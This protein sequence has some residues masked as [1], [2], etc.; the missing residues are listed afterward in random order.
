M[1]MVRKS[2][3][4]NGVTF[5]SEEVPRVRSLSI[6]VYVLAGSR[7]E[8]PAEA[9]L[10]HF[11]EHM[12][13]KGTS[14]R[15][16]FEIALSLEEVGGSLDAYT[17]RELT[18]FD[19]RAL[20]E[21]LPLAADVLADI[22]RNPVF[23]PA[24]V[25]KE[26]EVILEELKSLEDTPDDLVHD[27]FAAE[28]WKAHPL[29][30]SVLGTEET[31]SRFTQEKG[32]DYLKRHY[33]GPRVVIALAGS[34]A[35]EEALPLMERHFSFPGDVVTAARIPPPSAPARTVRVERDLS[36][37]YLCLG[38]PTVPFDHPDRYAI[39]VLTTALG[40]GMS[41]RLFQA[42]RERE[43]LVYSIY[44]YADFYEDTGALVT[45]LSV[46]PEKG[47]RALEAT[48]A[49][50]ERFR[51]DGISEAELESARQQIRGGVI[52]GLESMSTRMSR[53]ARSEIYLHRHQDEDELLAEVA[54]VS[55]EDVMRTAALYLDPAK[56]TRLSLGPLPAAA[57]GSRAARA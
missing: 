56:F 50:I 8:T 30:H 45:A 6:G 26:K 29:G 10:S 19:A 34:V 49:E 43:G 37:A 53:L 28:M 38:A 25:E 54:R 47:E 14:R 16:A 55:R 46:G 21:S 57:T 22:L 4:S 23:D 39:H 9:G 27:L 40:G 36:Q 51:K 12:V 17:S 18:C 13:F 3:L 2:V 11:A 5:L 42:V 7:D 32:L 31:V 20:D 33:R 41:S 35:H 15:S 44:T 24:E 48:L 1:S 52:M